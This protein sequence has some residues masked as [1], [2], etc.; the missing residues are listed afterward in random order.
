MILDECPVSFVLLINFFISLVKH[1]FC[2]YILNDN[3][4][5]NQIK[6]NILLILNNKYRFYTPIF[7]LLFYYYTRSLHVS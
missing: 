3:Y 5:T 1:S 4:Q 2:Y 7:I 6:K